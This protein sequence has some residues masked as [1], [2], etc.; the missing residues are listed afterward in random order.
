MSERGQIANKQLLSV[1]QCLNCWKLCIPFIM[2]YLGSI[3]MDH[4]ISESCYTCA[5]PGIF[6]RQGQG[7]MARKQSGRCF[8]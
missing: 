5:D 3:G 2:L 1:A 4:V 7:Q 6:F 8:F